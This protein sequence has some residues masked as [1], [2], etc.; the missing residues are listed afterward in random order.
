MEVAKNNKDPQSLSNEST[1]PDSS[2]EKSKKDKKIFKRG[3]HTTQLIEILYL[4]LTQGDGFSNAL[5]E[6][7]I[8]A[9]SQAVDDNTEKQ[10]KR[11]SLFK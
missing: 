1:K 3:D 8:T 5:R 9:Y 10:K 2:R 6:N 4:I 11:M 7:I